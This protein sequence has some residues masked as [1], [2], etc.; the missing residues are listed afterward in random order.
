MTPANFLF[1]CLVVFIGFS[2]YSR[3]TYF[4]DA[5][6]ANEALIYRLNLIHIKFVPRGSKVGISYLFLAT[7]GTWIC[8]ARIF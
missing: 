5:I 8:P 2:R 4:A 1:E 6:P 3:S 7:G